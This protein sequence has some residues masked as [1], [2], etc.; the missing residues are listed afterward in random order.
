VNV[1]LTLGDPTL[2]AEFQTNPEVIELCAQA[3]GKIDGYTELIGKKEVREAI[4]ER[5]KFE[6][7]HHVT[8]TKDEVFL[9]FGCSMGIY[10][11][12]ATLANP[13]DNFL[14]PSPGFPLI[15]TM[16]SNMKIDAKFYE[17]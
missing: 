17:L 8:V 9:T 6:E 12:L 2:F 7:N 10:L 3:V 14:F 1:N 15:V 5:Y 11:S 4:A 16:G 13:G